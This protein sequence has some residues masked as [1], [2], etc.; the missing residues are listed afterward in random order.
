MPYPYEVGQRLELPEPGLEI[1]PE[2]GDKRRPT[3]DFARET[4]SAESA[5][6]Q[7]QMLGARTLA[8]LFRAVLLRPGLQ[9]QREVFVQAF[10]GLKTLYLTSLDR[11][12]RQMHSEQP[13]A[14][15]RVALAGPVAT[16]VADAWELADPS[17]PPQLQSRDIEHLVELYTLQTVSF[18]VGATESAGQ[19]RGAGF[20]GES[21]AEFRAVCTATLG[22]LQVWALR[23]ATQR[24]YLSDQH[25]QEV[26]EHIRLTLTDSAAEIAQGLLPGSNDLEQ[27]T[28][29]ANVLEGLAELYRYSLEA[30]F[31]ELSR[32]IRDMDANQKR[33][34]L[35]SI[36]EHPHG[37]LIECTDELFSTVAPGCYSL[38]EANGGLPWNDEALGIGASELSSQP[39]SRNPQAAARY[40]PGPTTGRQDLGCEYRDGT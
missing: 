31:T 35:K 9:A 18:G 10:E 39:S 15:L 34:Y 21:L 23:P 19:S 37:I 29:Y 3:E 16:L 36:P 14:V 28:I 7:S 24:L 17:T 20:R 38:L 25:P 11:I 6:L 32:R 26:V 8:P 1:T 40:S 5:T 33:S 13:E 2:P 12:C 4:S 30:Q 22:L 27:E